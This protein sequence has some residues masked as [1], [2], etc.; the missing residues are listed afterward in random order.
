ML[1]F[2]KNY[3]P[4]HYRNPSITVYRLFEEDAKVFF[5]AAT[6]NHGRQQKCTRSSAAQRIRCAFIGPV[7]RREMATTEAHADA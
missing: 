5:P 6:C 3:P 2:N 4:I 7:R 1:T